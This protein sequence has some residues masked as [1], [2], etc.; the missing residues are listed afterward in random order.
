MPYLLLLLCAFLFG[1]A[2]GVSNVGNPGSGKPTGTITGHAIDGVISGAVVNVYSYS[3]G[4]RGERLGGSVTNGAGAFAVEI[5]AESQLVLVEVT[6]GSYVEEAS[7]VEVQ[8]ADGQRLRSLAYYE[9]GQIVSTNVT[10]LTHMATALTEYKIA[11]GTGA[12]QA[13]SE[14]FDVIDQFFKVNS[15]GTTSLNIAEDNPVETLNEEALYGF[16]M[17]GISHWTAWASQKSGLAPHTNYTSIALVEVLYNDIRHDGL[18]D[19]VGSDDAN[20]EELKTFASVPL[21]ADEYRLM[22]TVHAIAVG[23]G[24]N[25]KTQINVTDEAIRN[26]LEEI[27]NTQGEQSPLLPQDVD[28]VDI[29]NLPMTVN[30]AAS[31]YSGIYGQQYSFTI[32]VDSLVGADMIL[33]Y[34]DQDPDEVPNDQL[35]AV[36]NIGS[37]EAPVAQLDISAGITSGGHMIYVVASD[38][39]GGSAT[40]NF[41]VTF[42]TDAPSISFDQSPYLT[43][44]PDTTITG[45]FADNLA[46]VQSIVVED[47]EAVLSYVANDDTT[48]GQWTAN[49]QGLAPGAT[50]LTVTVTDYAGNT[51]A[52]NNI[53]TVYLDDQAPIIDTSGG[54]SNV[55]FSATGDP[56][57]LEDNN[58]IGTPLYIE[59][60][61]IQDYSGENTSTVF[62]AAGIPYFRFVVSDLRAIPDIY[63]DT[64][65]LTT[66]VSIKYVKTDNNMDVVFPELDNVAKTPVCQTNTCEYLVPLI[67]PFLPIDW[68]Q[69]TPTDEH[70]IQVRV[71]D[72]AGNESVKQFSFYVDFNVPN[73]TMNQTVDLGDDIFSPYSGSGFV[74]REFFLN[75]P[76]ELDS[77]E[78]TF[79]N[80]ADGAIWVNF[81]DDSIHTVQQAVVESVRE[82]FVVENTFVEWMMGAMDADPQEIPEDWCPTVPGTLTPIASVWNWNGTTFEQVFP[83]N[84]PIDSQQIQVYVDNPTRDPECCTNVPHFDQEF[85]SSSV[86]Y[87]PSTLTYN[88]DYQPPASS[89]KGYIDNWQLAHPGGST[90]AC[91]PQQGLKQQLYF[92]YTP[93]DGYPA[94]SIVDKELANLPTFNTISFRAYNDTDA[95][96]IEPVNGWYLIPVDKT[97]TVTKTAM[98]PSGINI[99]ADGD[100]IDYTL[101]TN[102]KS[103]AWLVNRK[104]IIDAVHDIGGNSVSA[105]SIK[106]NVTEN[107]VKKYEITP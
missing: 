79:T 9:S 89:L 1:C 14:A 39:F 101:R 26:Q 33:V 42:D 48:S 59:T 66:E 106:S 62:D 72:G 29:Q 60:D 61:S 38:I 36:D 73:I 45:I 55:L 82:N 13:A 47:V 56:L 98:M 20:N 19:G 107:G 105:M 58:P 65:E 91:P 24:Q 34:L 25:N 97:V 70:I 64:G 92:S 15:R 84:G 51:T 3:N 80:P 2:D 99:H 37:A 32:Q 88:Y 52:L 71:M 90:R 100:T 104:I 27:A 12:I 44:S 67:H 28:I 74:D 49:L 103:I 30:V 86:A 94:N 23:M 8:V 22:F 68:D 17:A 76:V 11:N 41:E 21:N 40:T 93:V 35:V 81:S 83:P 4:T 6:G 10:P 54:H 31:E 102:D 75:N 46:G 57:P 43:D 63:T 96:L 53:A 77:M 7:G 50:Q 18:M 85:A 69:A 95:Q 5:Q 78:Y 87:P 16:Y